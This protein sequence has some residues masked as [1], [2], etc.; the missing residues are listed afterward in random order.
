M[1]PRFAGRTA[2]ITGGGSGIGQG[3]ALA[4]AAEGALVTVVGRTEDTLAETVRLIQ[5]DGAAARHVVADV[6]DDSVECP[7]HAAGR[8]QQ[9][10]YA[11]GSTVSQKTSCRSHR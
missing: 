3:P 9:H 11:Q 8:D 5:A 1:A 7:R 2:L 6:R 10:G 4:L